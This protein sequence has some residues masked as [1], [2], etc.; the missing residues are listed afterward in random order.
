[1]CGS[2]PEPTRLIEI[3]L[4]STKLDKTTAKRNQNRKGR[5]SDSYSICRNMHRNSKILSLRPALY[6]TA[7]VWGLKIP[8][9]VSDYG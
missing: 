8:S 4:P 9:L 5:A 3:K 6:E 2:K 7:Y 1:M